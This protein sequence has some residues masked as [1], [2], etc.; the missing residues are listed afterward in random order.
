MRDHDRDI[1][2]HAGLQFQLRIS[3]AD[4]GVVG[5]HVLHVIGALRTC[6]TLP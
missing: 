1:R 3:H 5:D 4:H 6:T 2:R